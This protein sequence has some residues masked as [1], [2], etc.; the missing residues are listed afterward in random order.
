MLWV[1]PEPLGVLGV[2]GHLCA[3]PG[4]FPV[5][6]QLGIGA[7]PCSLLG[8][9]FNKEKGFGLSMWQDESLRG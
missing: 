5:E 1:P 2:L 4:E 3:K 8:C 9:G 7:V 6:S